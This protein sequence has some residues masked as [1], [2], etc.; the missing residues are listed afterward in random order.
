VCVCVC[1]ER[2]GQHKVVVVVVVWGSVCVHSG[3]GVSA[4]CFIH[5][6]IML[7]CNK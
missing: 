6:V 4:G 5:T 2:E 1:R 7:V 3:G